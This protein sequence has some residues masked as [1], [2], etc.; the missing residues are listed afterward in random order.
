MLAKDMTLVCGE[1]QPREAAYGVNDRW[2][3]RLVRLRDYAQFFDLAEYRI[4]QVLGQTETLEGL[5]RLPIDQ[6]RCR[7]HALVEG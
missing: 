6:L 1:G 5:I 7:G 2:A 3:R 4:I